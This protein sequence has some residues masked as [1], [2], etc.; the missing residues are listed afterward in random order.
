[1]ALALNDEAPALMDECWRQQEHRSMLRLSQRLARKRTRRAALPP[2]SEL[3]R[4]AR[5]LRQAFRVIAVCDAFDAVDEMLN[6][7]YTLRE[8]DGPKT[9]RWEL[10]PEWGGEPP[11][12]P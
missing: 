3:R 5:I 4:E 9:R 8:Y 2:A 7:G 10:L 1:M 11:E 12:T 6:A